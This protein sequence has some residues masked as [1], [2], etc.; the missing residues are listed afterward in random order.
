MCNG[1]KTHFALEKVA[2]DKFTYCCLFLV[3]MEKVHSLSILQRIT[4]ISW[5]DEPF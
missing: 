5:K 1:Q 2:E 4:I 3:E